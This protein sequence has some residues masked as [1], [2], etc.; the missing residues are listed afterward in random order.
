MFLRPADD[1]IPGAVAT[2]R[3]LVVDD[4]EAN[5]DLLARRL[6]RRGHTVSLADGGRSA[7]ALIAERPFDLVLLDVMMPELSG[8][9][10]LKLLR[11]THP[12]SALPVIMAT[13]RDQ[14]EDIVEAL[15]LGAND[16]VTKPLD[17]PV[18]VARVQTQLALKQAVEESARLERSLAERNRE[19]EAVN[20]RLG[21]ANRRME[22]DLKAAARVQASFLPRSSPALPGVRCAW[23]YRPCDELGGDGLNAFPLD[24]RH[25]AL[26][27][28]DVCGHGVAS[29]LLSVSVSRVLSP[30]ADPSSVL[31]GPAPPAAVAD[32]LNRMFPFDQADQYFTM[33]YGVLDG[34]SGELR[35]VSAGHPGL[36]F[37]PASGEAG[38]IEKR[39]FPVGLATSP[40]SEQLMTLAPGDRVY[41]YSDGVPEAA[42]P[43]GRHYGAGRLVDAVRRGRA[44]PLDQAVADLADEVSRWCGEAGPHDDVSILA[45]E[46]VRGE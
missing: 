7:L 42:N 29:A 4:D 10:V 18:V 2:G 21:A 36:L 43:E 13:A 6:E 27:V 23:I 1:D 31:D 30:P 34:E 14:S 37:D 9:E 8:L 46:R 41:F 45:V 28:F 39:G 40:Y 15:Q 3:L 33:V 24:D 38:V 20:F 22:R 19:L 26:Y 12:A 32:H 17:F 16:Y 25:A 35:Y 44:Y 5:R 11:K